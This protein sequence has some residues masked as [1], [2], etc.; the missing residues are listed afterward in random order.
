MFDARVSARAYVFAHLVKRLSPICMLT[1]WNETQHNISTRTHIHMWVTSIQGGGQWC[2]WSVA[3]VVLLLRSRSML[4]FACSDCLAHLALHTEWIQPRFILSRWVRWHPSS[5]C[6]MTLIRWYI[7]FCL[8][9]PPRSFFPITSIYWHSFTCKHTLFLSNER[10]QT[11]HESKISRF[12]SCS[13][14]V[15]WR[16]RRSWWCPLVSCMNI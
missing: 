4:I 12:R 10:E 14:V 5:V 6:L 3:V 11:R 16:R 8:L 1:G 2:W 7:C 13:T 15:T 9:C